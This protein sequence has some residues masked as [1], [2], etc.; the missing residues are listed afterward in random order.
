MILRQA[1]RARRGAAAPARSMTLGLLGAV[2]GTAAVVFVAAAP[3]A[4]APRAVLGEL[5]SSDG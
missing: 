3:A 1:C 5:F 2:M 4:A